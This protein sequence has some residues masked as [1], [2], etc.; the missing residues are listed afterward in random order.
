[1]D[2]N[3]QHDMAQPTGLGTVVGRVEERLP[4]LPEV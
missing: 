1:M 4:E 3:A 2:V